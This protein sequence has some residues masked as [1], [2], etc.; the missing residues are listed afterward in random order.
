M[1][2]QRQISLQNIVREIL[3]EGAV[4]QG[5]GME[6]NGNGAEE[7]FVAQTHL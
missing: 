6:I 3:D 7:C 5:K 4:R 1:A 2:S